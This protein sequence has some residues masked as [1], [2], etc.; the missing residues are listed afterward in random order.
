[1]QKIQLTELEI[2]N[3]I[4]DIPD[5]E[6]PVVTIEDLG[7]LRE[8]KVEGEKVIVFITPTYSGCPAM[9]T[10]EDE[11][12]TILHQTGVQNFE[13]KTVFTPVWT[14]DWLS[15]EA[16]EKLRNYGISPPEKSS[17]DKSILTTHF[18]FCPRCNSRNTEIISQF[19]STACKALYKCIDCLEPFNHF[20]C[21]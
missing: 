14:T 5:P 20:K 18:V 2:Y 4:A 11:I 21:H 3:L 10:I 16:K 13:V 7:V 12:K 6:I 8:V 19:G 17:T 9:K 1:M 15:E